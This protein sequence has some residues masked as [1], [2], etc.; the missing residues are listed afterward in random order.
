MISSEGLVTL[1]TPFGKAGMAKSL[2]ISSVPFLQ[3]QQS[4]EGMGAEA[5]EA[6]LTPTP[7]LQGSRYRSAGTCL[8]KADGWEARKARTS[9]QRPQEGRFGVSRGG[10][11]SGSMLTIGA[12]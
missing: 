11:R 6:L 1:L 8:R 10:G 7:I 2:L 9:G 12:D 3:G 5:A 4:P